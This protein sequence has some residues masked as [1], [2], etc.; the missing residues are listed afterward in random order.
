M[1]P[2]YRALLSFVNMLVTVT[3]FLPAIAALRAGRS[4]REPAGQA[5]L[6]WLV[7]AAVGVV[8]FV[9]ASF[10]GGRSAVTLTIAAVATVMYV[11]LLLPHTLA[12][13]GERARRWQWPAV[14]ASVLGATAFFVAFGPGREFRTVVAPL[15]ALPMWAVTAWAIAACVRRAPSSVGAHDWFWILTGQLLLFSIDIFRKPVTEALMERHWDLMLA[16][17]AAM[18]ALYTVSHVLVARGML[19]RQRGAPPPT[20]LTSLAAIG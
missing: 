16:V 18:V 6:A 8:H 7:I 2:A 4:S 17:H 20:Q 11:P 19:R 13:I 1:N 12:W 10:L 9:S 14:A 15:V 5:A 3:A